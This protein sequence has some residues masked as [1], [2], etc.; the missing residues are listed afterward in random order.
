MGNE[1]K[2]RAASA[3]KVY[4]IEQQYAILIAH[5]PRLISYI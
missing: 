5:H 1:T 3:A 2:G 4:K